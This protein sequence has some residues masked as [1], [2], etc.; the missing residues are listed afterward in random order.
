MTTRNGVFSLLGA[1]KPF[2]ILCLWF[3][4][5]FYVTEIMESDLTR[6]NAYSE[7][8]L[9]LPFPQSISTIVNLGKEKFAFSVIS[10]FFDHFHRWKCYF[11][12]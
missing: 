1:S 12:L 3:L 4:T 2:L 8:D 9:V 11:S 10:E 6:Q 5:H 7:I